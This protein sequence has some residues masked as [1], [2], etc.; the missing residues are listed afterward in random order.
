MKKLLIIGML[1]VQSI[2]HADYAK[3][4]RL[5][6]LAVGDCV[7]ISGVDIDKKWINVSEH[8]VEQLCYSGF[9]NVNVVISIREKNIIRKSNKA[10]YS[11]AVSTPYYLKYN[12]ES[13]IFKNTKITYI[14]DKDK[15]VVKY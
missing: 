8:Q 13:I 2:S 12:N 1:L 9:T 10:Y 14:K 6:T 3:G 11:Y 15:I 4:E 7:G 5:K